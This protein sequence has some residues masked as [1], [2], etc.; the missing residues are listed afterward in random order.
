MEL[1]K[2]LLLLVVIH[3]VIYGLIGLGMVFFSNLAQRKRM[4]KTLEI[5]DRELANIRYGYLL[6]GPAPEALDKGV[7]L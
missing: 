1:F 7:R 3:V 6:Y 4:R 2:A 5:A